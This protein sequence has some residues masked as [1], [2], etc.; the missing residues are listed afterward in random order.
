M[1]KYFPKIQKYF[2]FERFKNL[3]TKPKTT[4][5]VILYEVGDYTPDIIARNIKQKGDS[6]IEVRR[7]NDA[8]LRSIVWLWFFVVC[9][10]WVWNAIDPKQGLHNEMEWAWNADK[11]ENEM[12]LEW[13]D[14]K[15]P[16]FTRDGEPIEEYKKKLST[17]VSKG[18]KEA[19]LLLSVPLWLVVLASFPK[20]RPL[21]FDTK[22][23]LV[24]TWSF[25]SFYITRYPK[26]ALGSNQVVSNYLST[27]MLQ[28]WVRFLEHGG[29]VFHIPHETQ[30]RKP[31]KI[32]VGIF[33]PACKYQNYVLGK[34]LNHYL[35]SS[36]PSVEYA[37]YFHK[38]KFILSDVF[39]WFYQ[40]SLFPAIGYNEK[41]TEA[42]I[43]QWLANNPE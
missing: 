39:N 10:F 40:F 35:S 13:Q 29:L 4:P 43:Q 8:N 6:I 28:P 14:Y 16:N 20:W 32:D 21:R 22:R 31:A 25:G 42:K 23:R 1:M 18:K 17:R 12:I 38:E 24:Y 15:N 27:S 26:Q 34:F 3:T 37:S 36:N 2:S 5:Q 33:R 41:K 30:A 7:Y 11:I 9:F 19:W